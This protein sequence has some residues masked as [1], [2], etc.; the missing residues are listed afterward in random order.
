MIIHIFFSVCMVQS[1]NS[2]NKR[3]VTSSDGKERQQQGQQGQIHDD[4]NIKI[5]IGLLIQEAQRA[6]SSD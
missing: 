6:L 1:I 3:D 5:Y 2:V 4:R